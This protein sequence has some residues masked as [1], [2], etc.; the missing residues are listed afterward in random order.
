MRRGRGR[1]PGPA[2]RSG[3]CGLCFS[4]LPCVEFGIIATP[5]PDFEVFLYKRYSSREITFSQLLFPV[6]TLSAQQRGRRVRSS[7]G[8]GLPNRKLI[9]RSQMTGAVFP[10]LGTCG[11][12]TAAFPC[13][14]CS[15]PSVGHL[16]P[17]L[18]REAGRGPEPSGRCPSRRLT[19]LFSLV[20][21][22]PSLV[23]PL[24]HYAVFLSEDSS[25]DECQREEGPSSGFTE[26]LFF[27]APFEWS[28]LPPSV[29]QTWAW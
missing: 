12:P 1:W 5:P 29:S 4:G 9:P 26:S 17:R 28:L 8:S 13:G 24:R 15:W 18:Q 14:T 23:K 16:H 6:L 27:S 3:R 10:A 25:D 11:R 22:R 7:S 20:S 21:L 2:S 19:A